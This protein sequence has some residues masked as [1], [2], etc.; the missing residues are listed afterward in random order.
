MCNYLSKYL[1]V[2]L[3][4]A[5]LQCACYAQQPGRN[6]LIP[7]YSADPSVASFNGVYYLYGTSDID[8][9][10]DRMGP[11]VVWKS[12][13]LINWSYNGNVLPV[14]DWSKP[15]SYKDRN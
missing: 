5:A 7:D 14:I 3:F 1:F 12:P 8:Q 6:P 11:P 4:L 2:P 9:K 13:D 10:L 15:Y